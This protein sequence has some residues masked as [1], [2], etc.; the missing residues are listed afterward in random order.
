MSTVKTRM[1]KYKRAINTIKLMNAELAA[2]NRR[3]REFHAAYYASNHTLDSIL[4]FAALSHPVLTMYLRCM[5]RDHEARKRYQMSKLVEEKDAELAELRSDVAELK[6]TVLRILSEQRHSA[7]GLAAE[8]ALLKARVVDLKRFLSEQRH[9][10]TKLAEENA[11]LKLR[12]VGLKKYIKK[13]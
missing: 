11:T 6:A 1:T 3:I 10:P 13:R 5:R 7:R 4:R 2:A 8:N 12:I 9:W